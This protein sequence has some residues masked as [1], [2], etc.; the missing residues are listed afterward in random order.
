[1]ECNKLPYLFYI[2]PCPAPRMTRADRWKKRPCVLR[3]FLWKDEI[4]RQC[5]QNGYT[6]TEKLNITFVVPM[7]ESWSNKKRT[8]MNGQPHRQRPDRDNFLKAFQDAFD[9]DD[10]FVWDGNTRKVWG[11]EGRI[12][13]E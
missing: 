5:N 11:I 10:G 7:P 13:V 12:I 3:Y 2:E 9:G 1:M 4:K 6:L 8:I